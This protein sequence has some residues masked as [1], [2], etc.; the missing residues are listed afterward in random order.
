MI[1]VLTAANSF[2]ARQLG[3]LLVANGHTVR[4]TL[5]QRNQAK[6]LPWLERFAIADLAKPDAGDLFVGADAVLHL[7]HDFVADAADSNITGTM[8]FFAQAAKAGVKR[9]VFVSSYSARADAKSL[10]GKTK[11][12]IEDE[13]RG[14]RAV[15]VRPGLVLG[16]GGIYAR[17]V[18]AIAK[19]PA[20]PLLSGDGK[21]PF[22]SIELL[23]QALQVVLTQPA[24]PAQEFNLFAQKLATLA[25][26]LICSRDVL[27][28][29]TL[30]LPVPVG[31]VRIGLLGAG[32]LK[33]PLP[34]NVDNLDGFTGNQVQVHH[35][36]LQ[37]LGVTEETLREAV[38]RSIGPKDKKSWV[39]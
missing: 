21:I 34:V 4:G 15:I 18:A 6:D 26:L 24:L 16:A 25:E 29:R 36:N 28:V 9:Q 10:Y 17:M 7:A 27:G 35:G 23:A 22:I 8:S 32:R 5:R 33:L 19:F 14:H 1:I 3:P 20:V 2:L 37:L 31:L 13:F 30:L 38:Q 39:L 12:A 11:W